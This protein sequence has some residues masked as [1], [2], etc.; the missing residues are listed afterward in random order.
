MRS[1][2]FDAVCDQL[3]RMPAEA[4]VAACLGLASAAR[5]GA[6]DQAEASPLQV[7]DP[8]ECH[9]DDAGRC[10]FFGRPVQHEHRICLVAVEPEA[11]CPQSAK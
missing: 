11:A 8:V 4:R 6:A 3:A 10:E 1:A 7:F 5:Q 9:P 2:S